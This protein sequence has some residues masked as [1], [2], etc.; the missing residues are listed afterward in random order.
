MS[1][2]DDP[3]VY[4]DRLKG[5]LSRSVNADGTVD[6]EAWADGRKPADGETMLGPLRLDN[7]DAC[8]RTVIEEEI[9]GDLI[10]TGVWRGGASIFMRAAL[11]AY[12]DADRVVWVADSFAGLPPPDRAAFPED[13]KGL[14]E[15]GMMAVPQAEVEANFRRYG[16]LDERVRFLPGYFRD[17]LPSAPVERLAILRMDGDMYESTFVALESLYPK[18]APGGFVIVDDYGS[19]EQCRLAIEDFRSDYGID[20]P[21]RA[22]DWAEVTWRKRA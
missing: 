19:Y 10:E 14:L 18:V 5:V 8:V 9:P 15:E 22:T 2:A 3:R 17:T 11:E 6:P 13:A 4:L 20:E 21:L 12:G 7:L 16:L 1:L